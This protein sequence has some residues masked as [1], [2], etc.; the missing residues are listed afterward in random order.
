[1]VVLKPKVGQLTDVGFNLTWT[2]QALYISWVPESRSTLN[3]QPETPKPL[4]PKP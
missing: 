1:M 2:G 3:L 4:N